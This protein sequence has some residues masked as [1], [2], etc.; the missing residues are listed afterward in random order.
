MV[1]AATDGNSGCPSRSTSFSASST[2]VD[3]TPQ[4]G[5]GPASEPSRGRTAS[6]STPATSTDFV[7]TGVN[8]RPTMQRLYRSMATVSS[9]RTQRQVTGSIANTSSVVV[10]STTY[11]PGRVA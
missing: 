10:S 1:S 11:S 9:Q 7:D 6:N 2:T 3:G 5:S 8:R 4:Y